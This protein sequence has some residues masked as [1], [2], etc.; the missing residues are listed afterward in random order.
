MRE[1]KVDAVFHLFGEPF[2]IE[3]KISKEKTREKLFFT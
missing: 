2:A 3:K 1:E